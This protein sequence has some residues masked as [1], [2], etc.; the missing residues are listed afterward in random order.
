MHSKTIYLNGQRVAED[1]ARI[2]IF[3]RGF[4]FGDSVYEVI[5][6]YNG[7][8]FLLDEHLSRLERSLRERIDLPQPMSETVTSVSRQ[9]EN[10]D[11]LHQCCISRSLEV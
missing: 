3:D 5:R 4:Q 6:C 2:S 9:Q 10:K 8:P 11:G 1:A 7:V